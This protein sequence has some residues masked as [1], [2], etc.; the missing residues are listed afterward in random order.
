LTAI[1]LSWKA[2]YEMDTKLQTKKGFMT[3]ESCVRFAAKYPARC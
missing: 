1:S 2:W 3:A